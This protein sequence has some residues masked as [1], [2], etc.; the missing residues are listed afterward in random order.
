M[1]TQ[2]RHFIYSGSIVVPKVSLHLHLLI[3][4]HFPCDG[5]CN[6]SYHLTPCSPVVQHQCRVVTHAFSDTLQTWWMHTWYCNMNE[7]LNRIR[8]VPHAAWSLRNAYKSDPCCM[9][10]P[11]GSPTLCTNDAHTHALIY[12]ESRIVSHSVA[13][14]CRLIY[15]LIKVFSIHIIP[16]VVLIASLYV[17]LSL[18]DHFFGVV[19][20]WRFSGIVFNIALVG[21]GQTMGNMM[22]IT[23]WSMYNGWW[24]CEFCL[25]RTQRA[26]LCCG[27][28]G[29]YYIILFMID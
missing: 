22:I 6:S 12:A 28:C 9:A 1:N 8:T 2:G 7:I 5:T 24:M 13:F 3:G 18:G 15:E 10:L 4:D 20:L 19:K 26:R 29:R 23:C 11:L 21:F 16:F 25:I 17:H 27:C 14:W